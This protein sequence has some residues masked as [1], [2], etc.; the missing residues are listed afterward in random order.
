MLVEL[1]VAAGGCGDA[2]VL[3]QHAAGAG[4][5]GKNEI[6]AGQHLDGARRHVGQVA[7]GSGHYV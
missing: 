1:V 2:E 6:H 3:E 5:L 4:V 7:D